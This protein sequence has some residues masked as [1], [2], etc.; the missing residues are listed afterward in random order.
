L[1][2]SEIKE[3]ISKSEV[4][5]FPSFA[6]ALPVSWLE[7]MAMGKAIVASNIGW[8]M[9]MI[10]DGEDGFLRDPKDHELY[11]N[12]ICELL[13]NKDLSNLMGLNAVEKVKLKFDSELTA[14]MNIEAY[15]K[16]I[17]T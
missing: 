16:V 13:L 15:R 5:V 9:E 1:P 4:C 8:A 12:A 10:D 14:K 6:E 3:I 2:Y 11:A 7:A 17:Y